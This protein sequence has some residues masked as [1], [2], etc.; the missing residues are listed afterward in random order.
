MYKAKVVQTTGIDWKQVK[1]SLA[2]SMP[3]QWGNA[4]EL[5]T[6]F[7]AY[8]NPVV[9]IDRMLQGR[10]AGLS[11]N[12]SG[13]PGSDDKIIIRGYTSLKEKE[14]N[15]P[16]YVVNGAIMSDEEFAKISPSAIKSM[17]V[18][19]DAAATSIY[20]SQAANGAIVVTLKEGLE[21]YVSVAN[22]TLDVTFD[23]DMPYDIPTNG[24]EQTAT[25]QTLSL[26]TIYTHYA[27]PKLDKSAYLIAEILDWEKLN[28]LPGEA[29]I[30]MENTFVGKS[31]IDPNATTD[32]LKLTLGR[33]E[34]VVIKR[35]KIAD[36]SSVKFLGNNK[37]QKFTYEITVKNNK[38]ETITLSLKHQFPISTNKDIEV[39]LVEQ[40]DAEVNNETGVLNWKLALAPNEIKKVKF[41]YSIKYAKDKTVNLN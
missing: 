32:T 34:R 25:L 15:K 8:I 2:T 13:V 21:D 29:N 14:N 10:V 31:F 12:S 22:N 40:D 23:I 18:L 39:T 27:V 30:I 41:A 28:L 35:E 16:I 17:D 36:Y 4:P 19:K 5:N 33:D 26:K 6:W 9:S 37:L 7:V 1:L 24:K 3:S 11:V 20:G 38:S